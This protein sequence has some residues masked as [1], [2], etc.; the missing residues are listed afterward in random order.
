MVFQDYNFCF[1]PPFY[2]DQME[3]KLIAE[4]YEASFVSLTIMFE[5]IMTDYRKWTYGQGDL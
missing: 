2:V 5:T 1:E 3:A 4:Y